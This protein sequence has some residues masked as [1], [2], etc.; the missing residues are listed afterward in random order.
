MM[1]DHDARRDLRGV[2]GDNIPTLLLEGQVHLDEFVEVR[3][4]SR[5][6]DNDS[7]HVIPLHR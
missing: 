1:T 5:H 3:K 6:E 4:R 2:Y 7:I